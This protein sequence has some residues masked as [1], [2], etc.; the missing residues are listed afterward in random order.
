MLVCFFS[1]VRI[2]MFCQADLLD[3]PLVPSQSFAFFG[4]V[5]TNRPP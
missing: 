1:F 5:K 2:K 3:N 4:K